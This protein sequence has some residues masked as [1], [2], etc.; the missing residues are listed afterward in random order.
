MDK[1]AMIG[2][3]L[4]IF[5]TVANSVSGG[6]DGMMP[7]AY[8]DILCPVETAPRPRRSRVKG[9]RLG[10]LRDTRHAKR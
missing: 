2:K 1:P 7:L 10:A 8:E 3:S 9:N 4:A 6:V 5:R